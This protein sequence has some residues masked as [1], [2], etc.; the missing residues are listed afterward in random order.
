MVIAACLMYAYCCMLVHDHAS[1]RLS[2]LSHLQDDRSHGDNTWAAFDDLASQRS[3]RLNS[4]EPAQRPQ[5]GPNPF[6]QQANPSSAPNEAEAGGWAAFA[7]DAPAFP[8]TGPAFE[9]DPP[10]FPAEASTRQSSHQSA[11]D[12]QASSARTWAAFGDPDGNQGQDA[13]TGDKHAQ[14]S[15]QQRTVSSG[16]KSWSDAE[17]EESNFWRTHPLALVDNVD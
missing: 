9:E 8:S 15:D 14:T 10:A 13:S 4:D 12:A 5:A 7:A 11:P 6:D 17:F 16:E 2:N 1:P 3:S